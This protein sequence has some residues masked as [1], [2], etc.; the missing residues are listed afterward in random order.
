MQQDHAAAI[1][2]ACFV[3]V[4]VCTFAATCTEWNLWY[5][6]HTTGRLKEGQAQARIAILL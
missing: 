5:F 1:A 3:T 6:Q 2:A 4:S